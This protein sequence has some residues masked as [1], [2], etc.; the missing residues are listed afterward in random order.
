[1][2]RRTTKLDTNGKPWARYLRWAPVEAP[3]EG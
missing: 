3:D 2:A 1:M